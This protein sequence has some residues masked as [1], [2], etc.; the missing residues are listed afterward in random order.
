MYVIWNDSISIGDV[1]CTFPGTLE[2]AKLCKVRYGGCSI[3]WQNNAVGDLFPHAKYGIGRLYD[4]SRASERISIHDMVHKGIAHPTKHGHPTA[5]FMAHVGFEELSTHALRPEIVYDQYPQSQTYDIII[6]PYILAEIVRFW[7][8]DRWQKVLNYLHDNGYTVGCLGATALPPADDLKKISPHNQLHFEAY[9][10]MMKKSMEYCDY[11]FDR[12]LG[13]VAYL[14]SK[15]RAVITVDSGPARLMHAV[16]GNHL[17]LCNS[18]VAKEWGTY[19]EATTVFEPLQSLE[20]AR[21]IPLVATMLE[22]SEV[23]HRLA[24]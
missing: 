8:L 12:P 7:P 11:V 20:A 18:S 24:Q 4:T 21:V 23:K 9:K 19:P 2:L 15:A 3:V 14:M 5:Q 10:A 6:S 1:L 16:G 13:E 22:A 17:L